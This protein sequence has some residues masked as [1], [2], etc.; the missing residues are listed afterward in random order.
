MNEKEKKLDGKIALEVIR[1]ARKVNELMDKIKKEEQAR[2]TPE[3]KKELR[4][5]GKKIRKNQAEKEVKK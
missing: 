1:R 4:E 2:L 3:E 5:L